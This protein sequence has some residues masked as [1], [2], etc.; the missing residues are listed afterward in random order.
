MVAAAARKSLT[1]RQSMVTQLTDVMEEEAE[2]DTG[3][4]ASTII[5]EAEKETRTEVIQSVPSTIVLDG[6]EVGALEKRGADAQGQALLTS[7]AFQLGNS[8]D[9]GGQGESRDRLSPPC[10][11]IDG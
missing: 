2:D 7:E 1:A 11:G 3:S 10:G 6:E 8:T 4:V 5:P 9:S